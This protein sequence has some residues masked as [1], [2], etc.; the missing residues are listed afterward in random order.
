M[1]A[2]QDVMIREIS[3]LVRWPNEHQKQNSL[4]L[5]EAVIFTQC[6]LRWKVTVKK[7]FVTVLTAPLNL[8]LIWVSFFLTTPSLYSL[9]FHTNI[10]TFCPLHFQ[11]RQRGIIDF[12]LRHCTPPFH[13]SKTD[14]TGHITHCRHSETYTAKVL[15]RWKRTER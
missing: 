4:I 11:N 13:H 15:T 14:L 9:C 5:A 1:P 12:I 6:S 2:V 8:Y 10:C 3:L 7:H